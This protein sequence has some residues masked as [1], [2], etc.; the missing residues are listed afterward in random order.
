MFNP[1][2]QQILKEY[3]D[4]DFAYLCEPGATEEDLEKCGDRLL[5]FVIHEVAAKEDCE[6]AIEAYRRIY[7]AIDD[8]QDILDIITEQE[9]L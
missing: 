3:Q 9:K 4:G 6:S 8:L 1:I 7:R 5:I 2:Q